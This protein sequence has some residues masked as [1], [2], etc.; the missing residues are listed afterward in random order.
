MPFILDAPLHLSDDVAIP[1]GTTGVRTRYDDDHILLTFDVSF[2]WG[3][4]IA[5][6]EYDT[7]PEVW[8]AIKPVAI[9]PSM[10]DP[11]RAKGGIVWA[12]GIGVLASLL[13]TP[14]TAVVSGLTTAHIG[15]ATFYLLAIVWAGHYRGMWAS[16]SAAIAAM[17][18]YNL[19]LVEPIWVLT[20]PTTVEV[21]TWIAWLSA[22]IL[23]PFWE[24]YIPNGTYTQ[25]NTCKR[26]KK[27][28]TNAFKRRL[29]S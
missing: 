6:D 27:N 13:M 5:L 20:W 29:S 10:V 25:I 19:C 24:Q 26:E 4:T 18:F 15:S 12:I 7:A 28:G 23:L 21:S 22:A 9:N 16:L 11:P 3:N 1:A 2:P 8:A 14:V 17:L